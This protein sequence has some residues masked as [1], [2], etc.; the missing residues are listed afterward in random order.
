MSNINNGG[1][2]FPMQGPQS[3]HSFAAAAIE[4]ISDPD[5]RDAAYMKARAEAVGGMTLRDYFI[6]HA[7][8][9]P[10]PWFQPKMPPRPDATIWVSDDG[11]RKYQ[12][13]RDAE[14]AEG[15]YCHAFN[16]E[17]I[18]KWEDDFDK[19]RWVQWPAAWA[20]EMLRAREDA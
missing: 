13:R 5:E 9:A 17:A 12:T 1:P 16:Q 7:P 11:E 8:A 6:A 15:G 18:D 10:Q 20:D 2:A 3:I 4:G 19:Q 14:K